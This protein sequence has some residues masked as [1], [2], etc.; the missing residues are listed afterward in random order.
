MLDL[1]IEFLEGA[2]K[3]L[4]RMVAKLEK[5][6]AERENPVPPAGAEREGDAEAGAVDRVGTA[7]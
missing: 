7:R 5:E 6:L 2:V 3:V 1:L 4:E